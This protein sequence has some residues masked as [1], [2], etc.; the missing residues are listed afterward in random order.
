MFLYLL[1]NST[2]IK[3]KIQV[4]QDTCDLL[5]EAG[6][7]HWIQARAGP[8]NAK[9]KG[10]LNTFWVNPSAKR[11]L[12]SSGSGTDTSEASNLALSFGLHCN[13]FNEKQERLVDWM[14][15]MLS[16][17]IK[18]VVAM[19]KGKSSDYVPLFRPRPRTTC[20]DEVAECIQLPKFD[21]EAFAASQDYRNVCLE[22]NIKSELRDYVSIIASTYADNPFHN[23]EHACHVTMSTQKFLKRIV[24]PKIEQIMIEDEKN[25]TEVASK[26]HSYTYGINSDPLTVLAILISALVHD[27]DH[28]GVSNMQL[29]IESPKMAAFYTNRSIA[30]QNSLDI[31]WDL[32]M[33]DQFANLHRC[34]F[35]SEADLNRFRQVL[36]NVVLATDIFDK[37]INA[38]RKERWKKAFAEGVTI[39]EQVNDLRGTIV[40]EHI[41]QASDVSHTMQHWHVYRKWNH[42]LFTEMRQAFK[43]GRMSKDPA[44]FWYTGELGFFDNYVIPLAKKLESCNVFGVSS[45]ECYIYACKNREEWKER[46]QSIVAQMMEEE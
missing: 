39:D 36:V 5:K 3:D 14:T 4:S 9:G 26:I 40:L 44:E 7:D 33:S 10:T 23:F 34:L 35:S 20:L 6:K 17:T 25:I 13:I 32:L 21:P 11:A 28:R 15:E 2:G 16:E 1:F 41:I 22:D 46:G 45:D 29:G 30:E 31:S 8:V 27:A 12:S 37:E 18:K 24:E 42:K 38:A 19:R 43:A